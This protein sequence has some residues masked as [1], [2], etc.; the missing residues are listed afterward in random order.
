[1]R[2]DAGGLI[3]YVLST[4]DY[5]DPETRE[6]YD[7]ETLQ[8]MDVF[9]R[10]L[11]RRSVVDAREEADRVARERREDRDA[12]AGLE[13]VAG[14]CAARL[15]EAVEAVNE[16]RETV[17]DASLRML[18]EV[19]PELE[20]VFRELWARDAGEASV[21]ARQLESF[22]VGPPQRP[23]KDKYG[24]LSIA[25]DLFRGATSEQ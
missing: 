4:G 22:L 1:L 24:M 14:E 13:C 20:S 16:R 19:V 23:T 3:D 25:L 9:G 7:D 5:R 6:P 18:T 11:G 8:R 17:E 21:C 12:A 10:R 2:V 15:F